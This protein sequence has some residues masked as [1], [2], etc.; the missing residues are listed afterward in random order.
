MIKLKDKI[1]FLGRGDFGEQDQKRLVFALK[2]H[3]LP[4][5]L[6]ISLGDSLLDIGCK[7][8]E[9]L[10]LFL[11]LGV[12]LTGTDSS[13][14]D[15]EKARLLLKHRVDLHRAEPEDL[16]FSDNSHEYACIVN[17][18]EYAANPLSAL[19]E[20]FR[21]TR[22]KVFIGFVNRYGYLGLNFG[23]FRPFGPL[24]PPRPRLFSIWELKQMCRSLL[25][26]VP[27]AWRTIHMVGNKNSSVSSGIEDIQLLQKNPFGAYGG[28]VVTLNPRFKTRPLPLTIRTKRPTR[29]VEC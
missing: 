19:E 9:G 8:G 14:Q 20:A 25:G 11:E 22:N 4:K 1:G 15:L 5:M 26:D 16:P 17:T 10:E 21:V 13:A 7:T 24:N 29:L 12:N 3:L 18:L 23:Y 6:P 2:C 27:M 28:L